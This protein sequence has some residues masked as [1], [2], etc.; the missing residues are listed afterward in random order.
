MKYGHVACRPLDGN[1][2]QDKFEHVVIVNE[3]I[4]SSE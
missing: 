4:R 3:Q 2:V 1:Q